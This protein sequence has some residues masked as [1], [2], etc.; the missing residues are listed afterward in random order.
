MHLSSID[1]YSYFYFHLPGTERLWSLLIFMELYTHR[2]HN[3]MVMIN[4]MDGEDPNRRTSL[5][6]LLYILLLFSCPGGL[7]TLGLFVGD[8]ANLLSSLYE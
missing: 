4:I 3:V 1:L 2:R 6:F 5:T 7:R 8:H